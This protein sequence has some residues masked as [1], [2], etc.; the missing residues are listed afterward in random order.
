MPNL[1]GYTT[2][3]PPVKEVLI[4]EKAVVKGMDGISI[5]EQ[6]VENGRH[7]LTP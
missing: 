4:Q 1:G 2:V 6:S 7:K 5:R 3:C